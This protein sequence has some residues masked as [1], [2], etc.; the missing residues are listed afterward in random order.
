MKQGGTA[1][2]RRALE[3]GWS[4][5]SRGP[6]ARVD[7]LTRLAR[8]AD[9]L[10]YSV[11]TISDH[12]VLPS[13]SSAPYPYDNTGAFPGG[14]QQPYL[15]PIALA[16][17]LLAA[18]RRVRVASLDL[19]AVERLAGLAAARAGSSGLRFV[20]ERSPTSGTFTIGPVA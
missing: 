15:E 7:V 18:T 3:L 1:G 8:T 16:S 4:L 13:R 11:I 9:A 12:V 17:W 19:P 2:R 20:V 14:S 5:P 6:L 10:G